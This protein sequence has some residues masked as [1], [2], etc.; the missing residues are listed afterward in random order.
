VTRVEGDVWIAMTDLR[1]HFHRTLREVERDATFTVVRRGIVV[2]RLI[3]VLP[4][5]QTR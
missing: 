5:N 3:P 1:R 4:P 2:A